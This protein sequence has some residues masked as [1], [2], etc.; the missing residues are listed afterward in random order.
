MTQYC[1]QDA[2][3]KRISDA[4][5]EY[6]EAKLDSCLR[7]SSEAQVERK[8]SKKLQKSDDKLLGEGYFI[9]MPDEEWRRVLDFS[10]KNNIYTAHIERTMKKLKSYSGSV[11]K[12][13]LKELN[14][15]MDL[16]RSYHFESWIE[17]W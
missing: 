14:N 13:E 1:K 3:W 2:C 5:F 7:S 12:S 10:R 15:I 17:S 11:K 9:A 6:D 4:Y 8:E 16:I